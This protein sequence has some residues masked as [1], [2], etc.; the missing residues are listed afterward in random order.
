MRIIE[1]EESSLFKAPCKE[2]VCKTIVAVLSMEMAML[3]ADFSLQRSGFA[4]R[5]V[6]VGFVVDRVALGQVFL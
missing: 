3:V 6:H 2:S 4:P 5:L 1:S